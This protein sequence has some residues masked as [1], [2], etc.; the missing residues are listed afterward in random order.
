MK[1]HFMALSIP[2][3]D[4]AE[5]ALELEAAGHDGLLLSETSH[6]PFVGLAA[7]SQRTSGLE[8]ST[9]V[10]I[11]FA[12]NPMSTAIVA[13]DLQLLA[14][15]RF[16][17]G[18]GSQ[19]KMHITRRFGMP[20]SDPV[21]RMREYVMAMRAIWRSFATG[22]RLRFRGDFYRHTLIE[23]F[24]D[25]GPN[26]YGNPP[27]LLGG[28]GDKMTEMAGEIGDGFMAHSITTRRFLDEVTLPALRRGRK[29]AG[30]SMAGF[31]LHV[32]PMV[33]TGGNEAELSAAIRTAR[34]QIAFYTATPTYARLLKLHGYAE[35]WDELHRLA[36][37]GRTDEMPSVIDDS[38]LDTFAIVGE[39]RDVAAKIHDR[40]G[41]V[42]SSIAFYQMGV[43]DPRHWVPVCE[44]LRAQEPAASIT[45]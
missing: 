27:V 1:Y 4:I 3:D 41:D 5:M 2:P 17:L 12:R 40:F 15:G 18:M 19:L 29:E 22:E 36:T 24:Y 43:T 33:A 9:G 25:P 44:A 14:K 7:A 6:D 34:E 11:A 38:V 35:V 20:W 39:P 30:K 42:A 37:R 23:P 45:G 31:G 16:S 13:N 21:E 10:A 32:M 28:V 26:P 8:L